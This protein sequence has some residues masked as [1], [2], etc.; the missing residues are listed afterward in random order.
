MHDPTSVQITPVR[1]A[2][3]LASAVTL[4]RD[5]AA[6]LV[7]DLSYQNFEAELA[8]LPGQYAPPAGE[9]RPRPGNC[10]WPVIAWAIHLAVSRFVRWMRTAVA[11]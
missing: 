9:L 5:Y 2:D 7:I 10:C 4:F 3:D 8:A 6:S 11:R 1:T